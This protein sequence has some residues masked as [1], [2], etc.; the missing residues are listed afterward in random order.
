MIHE[1]VFQK[2]AEVRQDHPCVPIQPSTFAIYEDDPVIHLE[3][4]SLISGV[5]KVAV[6]SA[7]QTRLQSE[8]DPKE[9]SVTYSGMPTLIYEWLYSFKFESRS[10]FL[11]ILHLWF[12][13][14]AFYLLV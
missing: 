8:F 10:C 7:Q 6:G 12:F 11:F 3:P 2:P 14:E 13:V 9:S 5:E 1:K 4:A